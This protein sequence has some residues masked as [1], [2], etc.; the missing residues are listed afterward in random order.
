MIVN[1]KCKKCNRF[2]GTT[3]KSIVVNIKCSNS[4]CKELN[5][6]N[7]TMLTDLMKG[8]KHG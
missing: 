2:L 4:K 3:D 8:E 5:Q 1:I 7:I 6:F